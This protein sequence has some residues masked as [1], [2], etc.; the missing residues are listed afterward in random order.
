MQF[1]LWDTHY[2]PGHFRVTSA[3][4]FITDKLR[5]CTCPMKSTH[6][7][8]K[9]HLSMENN[10][11]PWRA[12]RKILHAHGDDKNLPLGSNA[13]SRETTAV[14]RKPKLATTINTCPREVTS[15]QRKQFLP[16][17]RKPPHSSLSHFY[18]HPTL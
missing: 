14:R 17:G 9:P 2:L 11:Y 16:M 7:H 1:H 18:Q 5:H 3:H 12:P 13:W 4:I 15:A 6:F 8:K 10:T